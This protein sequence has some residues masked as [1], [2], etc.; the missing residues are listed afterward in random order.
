MIRSR[1][2]VGL[3]LAMV[4]LLAWIAWNARWALFPF[5]IGG[6]VAYV[7]TPVVDRI[8][9]LASFVPGG[10]PE[11]NVI[12]RGLAVLLVYLVILGILIGLGLLV[13]P[14]ALDQATEFIDSFPDLRERAQDQFRSWLDQYRERVPDDVRHRIDTAVAEN[15]DRIGVEIASHTTDSFSVLTTTLGVLFGFVI[16]PFWLFYAL[17]DRHRFEDNFAAAVPAVARPDM[18]NGVRIADALLGRYLRGQLLLGGV[19]AVMTF[20]GLTIIDV[21]LTIALAIFAGITELIPIIG[22]WI[23]ALP[24]LLMAAAS[25]DPEK[26]LWVALLFVLV[27]QLENNLLVPRIQSQAVDLHPAIIILLLVAA[28]AVFGFIGLL[29]IVPLTAV[30]RELFWYADS[31][32]RGLDPSQALARSHVARRFDLVPPYD[33]VPSDAPPG[34]ENDEAA[35]D[36]EDAGDG[37]PGEP[38]D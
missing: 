27:Q 37:A 24:A 3:W 12:S 29:V 10:T 11:K 17:R 33:V 34:G 28:G 38:R 35:E 2:R 13:V 5:A 25:G 21:E 8:A 31:R 4:V 26:I 19:V 36:G 18:L 20:F 32:L 16:V 14:V 15:T 30:L 6:L 1:V 22:P 7:L 23:G 9:S